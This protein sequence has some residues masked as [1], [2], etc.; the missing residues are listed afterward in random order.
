METFLKV[1]G[2]SIQA[3]SNHPVRAATDQRGEQ[4][5]NKDAITTG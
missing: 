2:L 3:P 5:I 4:T 1:G